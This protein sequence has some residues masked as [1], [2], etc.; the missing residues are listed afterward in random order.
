MRIFHIHIATLTLMLTAL[1]LT[2]CRDKQTGQVLTNDKQTGED[3]EAP[4]IEGNKKILRWE[5]EEMTLFIKR[6][7]WNMQRTGTGMYYQILN[8]GHGNTFQE[9]DEISLKYK[10]FLLSG[11]MVYSSDSTGL[12]TFKVAKSEEIEALH[13]AALMLR[14]GAKA[15]LVIPSYM[16]YGVS[17]DGNKINGRLPVAMTIEIMGNE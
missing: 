1:L 7:G 8:E 10:T 5:D 11:E 9:G 4:Y 2:G 12:K 15:R 14:P 16:A 6:Y 3:K 17:G 13:E